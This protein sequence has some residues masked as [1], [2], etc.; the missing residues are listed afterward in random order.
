MVDLGGSVMLFLFV[1]SWVHLL[2]LQG[3]IVGA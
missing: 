2:P 1:R 3:V